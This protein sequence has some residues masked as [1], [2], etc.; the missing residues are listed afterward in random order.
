MRLDVVDRIC[1]IDPP[2]ASALRMAAACPVALGA[3]NPAFDAPSLFTAEPRITARSDRRPPEHSQRLE[4]DHSD[5][6]TKNR[7]ASVRI[8]RTRVSVR[9][10]HAALLMKIAGLLRNSDGNAA[11]QGPSSH[12]PFKRL[13]TRH[14]HRHQRRRT[15]RLHGDCWSPQVQF[16]GDTRRQIVVLAADHE[17][18]SRREPP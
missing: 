4:N 18:D 5:P 17:F 11:R 13:L 12:S 1:R 3:V 16:E 10:I 9:R 7:P 8:E 6:R 2:A 14:V 15:C